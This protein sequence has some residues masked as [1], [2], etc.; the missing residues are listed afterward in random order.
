[1][2][3]FFLSLLLTLA[4]GSANAD[5][6]N[7]IMLN[8]AVE[9]LRADPP[10]QVNGVVS[11]IG[12]TTKIYQVPSIVVF[13]YKV[14]VDTST[15][16]KDHVGIIVAKYSPMIHKTMCTLPTTKQLLDGEFTIVNIF[17]DEKEA[18]VGDTMTNSATCQ[19]S[20]LISNP[21]IQ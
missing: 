6:I 2:N 3:K 19:S 13:R 5:V 20:L 1:M 12:I 9:Q 17:V 10:I 14:A 16:D 21:I 7:N 15:I 18:Y 11:L 4:F 8:S